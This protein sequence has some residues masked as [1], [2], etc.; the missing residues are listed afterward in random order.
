MWSL[1]PMGGDKLDV[2][3]NEGNIKHRLLA[4]SSMNY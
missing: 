4:D 1:F 2:S 3:L